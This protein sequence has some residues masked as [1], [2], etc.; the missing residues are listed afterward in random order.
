MPLY[1]VMFML[2]VRLSLIPVI[3]EYWTSAY[4]G[5]LSNFVATQVL[6]EGNDG[7]LTYIIRKIGT[8]KLYRSY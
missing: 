6:V 5:R 8:L 3:L 7:E 4:T 1:P 2:L